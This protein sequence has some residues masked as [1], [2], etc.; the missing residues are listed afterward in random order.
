MPLW[1][2]CLSEPDPGE[3]T[4]QAGLNPAVLALL[5]TGEWPWGLWA[6]CTP[7]VLWAVGTK[8]SSTWVGIALGRRG[9]GIIKACRGQ[10]AGMR[11]L[12]AVAFSFLEGKLPT[13]ALVPGLPPGPRTGTENWKFRRV[14]SSASHSKL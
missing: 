9:V 2:P 6:S 4:G 14:A 13:N 5:G 7:A 8:S 3:G 11:E 12:T 1:P 10:A